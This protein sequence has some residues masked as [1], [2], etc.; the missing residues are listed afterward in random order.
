MKLV[1]ALLALLLT[2]CTSM[3]T[4]RPQ[5]PLLQLA[6]RQL[7]TSLSLTQRLGVMRLDGVATQ[8]QSLDALLEIDEKSVHLAGFALGQRILT[9]YWNGELLNSERHPLL[10][11]AIDASHILRD[12]QLVYWPADAV[13]AALPE[14]WSLSEQ[15]QR[16]EL[17]KGQQIEVEIHYAATP[18]WQGRTV[19]QNRSEGYQL[20]IDSQETSAGPGL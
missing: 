19:M 6:P 20:T 17:W 14:G 16:R 1:C 9:L 10:P 15:G 2:A 18:R 11:A 3:Q 4:A 7:G 13:L 8:Q 5:V 12:I